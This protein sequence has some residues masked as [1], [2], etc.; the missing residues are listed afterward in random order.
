MKVLKKG[1]GQKGWSKEC[2]CT[3]KGN[4]NGG[5]GAKLLVEQGDLFQTSSSAMGEV[6]Y[7]VTFECP[8]CK[9]WTDIDAAIPY[10]VREGLPHRTP[11]RAGRDAR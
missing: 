6:D 5:C 3:G 8:E 10:H 2:V 9:V 1:T 11:G 7:Y 4:G